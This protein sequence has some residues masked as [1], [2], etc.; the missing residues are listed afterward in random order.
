MEVNFYRI[1]L[2]LQVNNGIPGTN[3]FRGK[4]INLVIDC[5]VTQSAQRIQFD[6]GCLLFKLV[7]NSKC[8]FDRSTFNLG[9]GETPM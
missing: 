5:R 9:H 6:S 2:F 3:I 8:K 7:G 1:L 4:I